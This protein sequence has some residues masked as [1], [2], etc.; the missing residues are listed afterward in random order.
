MKKQ[1]LI[2]ALVAGLALTGVGIASAADQVQTKDQLKL[3]DKDQL[4]LQDKDKDMLKDQDRLRD[5]DRIYADEL[6]TAQER[7]AYR[8]RIRLAKTEQE[9]ERIRAEHRAQ[10]DARAKERGVTIMHRDGTESGGSG[11]SSGTG[12]KK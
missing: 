4:K 8:E 12:G 1:I 9:R 5:Q 2:N 6:L 3:Q 7:T 10:M 11:S